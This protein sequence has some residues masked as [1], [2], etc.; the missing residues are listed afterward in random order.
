MERLDH[1]VLLQVIKEQQVQQKRLLDQQ[2]KL[3][4][5]IE[6]QHKEIHQQRQDGEE[7]KCGWPGG[8]ARR[9]GGAE[10]VGPR[11]GG[12]LLKARGLS[13]AAAALRPASC[14][15]GFCG[16]AYFLIA[17]KL[18]PFS[19]SVSGFC[20]FLWLKPISSLAGDAQPEPGVAAPRSKEQ[21]RDGGT[22]THPPLQPL[23]PELRAP[24]QPP[25][26]PQGHSQRSLEQPKG[27]AGRV[28]AGLPGRVGTEPR[29]A[30]TEQRGDRKGAEPVAGVQEKAA[31]PDLAGAPGSPEKHDA[32]GLPGQSPDIL[33]GGS[34]ER[35]KSHKEAAAAGPSVQEVAAA[36]EAG[37]PPMKP[38]QVIRDQRPA[39]LSSRSGGAAPPAQAVLHQPEQPA[40]SARV[41][42]GHPEARKEALGGDHPGRDHVPAPREDTAIQEPGQRPDPE[43]G[44]KQVMPGAQKPDNAKPNRDLKVQVG[45]DLRR[46]RRDVAHA[47]GKPAPDEGFIIS[48]NPL[49]DVQVNDL[50]SALDTQLRQAAGGALRVVHS[51][52]IKQSPGALEEA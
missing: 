6:E 5:V 37:D 36:L 14:W 51:R 1:A 11:P 17:G 9:E 40:V 49:S 18:V 22:V 21:A 16:D 35:N 45:A 48:F 50:R 4:A 13:S 46:R 44:P 15:A 32:G 30:Q 26:L 33:G 28:P 2:E 43:L 23:E 52:Q 47:D 19:L 39:G 3:L 20:P 25:A 41:Q 27:A 8:G 38:Q 10:R 42:G 31:E 34:Q 7:G 29:A 12:L 24:G